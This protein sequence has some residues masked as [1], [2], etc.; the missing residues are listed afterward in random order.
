MVYKS[1]LIHVHTGLLEYTLAGRDSIQYFPS[2]LNI[3][4][5]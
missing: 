2:K 1:E 3:P 4:F 5:D